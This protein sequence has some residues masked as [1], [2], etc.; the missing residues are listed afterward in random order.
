MAR[1]QYGHG[2]ASVNQTGPHCV[3]QTGKTHSKPSVAR[4]AMC[5]WAFRDSASYWVQWRPSH[6]QFNAKQRCLSQVQ[7]VIF[8][9][10]QWKISSHIWLSLVR[11]KPAYARTKV[12][13]KTSFT[14]VIYFQR[15][16]SPFKHLISVPMAMTNSRW[17]ILWNKIV[18]TLALNKS[19]QNTHW[20]GRLSTLA[21]LCNVLQKSRWKI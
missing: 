7:C 10:M 12:K 13:H 16:S 19:N 3:N 11:M 5:E 15:Y 17:H 4:H 2:M 6:P 8:N 9:E 20:E 18:H 1:A 21:I 14:E